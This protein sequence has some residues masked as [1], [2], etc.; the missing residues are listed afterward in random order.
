MRSRYLL[1]RVNAL[2]DDCVQYGALADGDNQY[3]VSNGGKMEQSFMN[4]KVTRFGYFSGM[5]G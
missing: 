2:T 3:Y 5:K 4:F 1:A